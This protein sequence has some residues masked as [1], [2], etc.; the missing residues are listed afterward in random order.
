MQP[1]KESLKIFFLKKKNNKIT[2]NLKKNLELLYENN[3]LSQLLAQ[4]HS[5]EAFAK[6]SKGFQGLTFHAST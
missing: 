5:P 2:I 3:W 1:N 6:D 4:K